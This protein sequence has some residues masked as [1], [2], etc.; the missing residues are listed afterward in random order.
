M[1]V[2]GFIE[3]LNLEKPRF[4][5]VVGEILSGTV[6]RG[7]HFLPSLLSPHLSLLSICLSLSSLSLSLSKV[8]PQIIGH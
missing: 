2:F 1:F 3:K 7:T 8:T 5:I 4:V 6:E